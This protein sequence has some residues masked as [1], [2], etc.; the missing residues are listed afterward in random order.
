IL[1]SQSNTGTTESRPESWAKNVVSVGAVFHR[2][3]LA[4]DDD[5]WCLGASIG[6]AADGRIKPDLCHFGDAVTTSSRASDA[7][8]T[9]NFSGTSAA[10]PIT[11]GYFGLMF[12]MWHEGFFPGFGQAESVFRSRPHMTTAKALMINTARQYEFQGQTDDL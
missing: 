3:T 7:A 9:T 5:C 1:Q 4:R 10:T 11:A 8:F 6:P 12:Q 2:N